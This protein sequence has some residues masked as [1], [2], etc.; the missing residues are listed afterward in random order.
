MSK[1]YNLDYSFFET[2]VAGENPEQLM[3]PYDGNR[4]VDE[5]IVY[6][7]KDKKKIKENTLKL[8]DSI[9]KKDIGSWESEYYKG[10]YDE[11]KK[12]SDEDA[13][14]YLTCN[15]T[16]DKDNNAV[17]NINPA[18]K[19]KSFKKGQLFS[20]PFITLDGREVFQAR[21]GE[22]DWE[23][24][25]LNGAEIYEAAWDMVMGNKK[26]SNPYEE[27]I[28][29]N[30]KERVAYFSNFKNKENYVI[31]STAF[32]AYAFVDK[33]NWYELEPNINQ[34]DWVSNFYEKFIEPLDD[35][36][37]LTIYECKK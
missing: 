11:V 29:N 9:I 16:Y 2:I 12:M 19:Y 33:N 1:G 7:Y 32:W 8:Y 35:N 10:E 28:Y 21:K 31:H 14:F 4:L 13:Y 30:M 34:F 25:H 17:S 6:N 23:K 37:L 27:Q 36:T 26:P 15:Y 24:M 22:V 5:Y 20:V 3:K 18:G